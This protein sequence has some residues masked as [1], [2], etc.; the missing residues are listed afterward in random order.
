[1]TTYYTMYTFNFKASIKMYDKILLFIFYKCDHTINLEKSNRY[2]VCFEEIS[3]QTLIVR[4]TIYIS[5]LS[6]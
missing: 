6:P 1:M 2:K 4:F 3:C 5:S